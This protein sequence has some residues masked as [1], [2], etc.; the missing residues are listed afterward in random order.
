MRTDDTVPT[1]QW[2]VV[3]GA[4]CGLGREFARQL[5]ARGYHLV[6]VART[7]ER[8]GETSAEL[9][10][11]TC[12]VR[13]VTLDLARAGAAEELVAQTDAWG[14]VPEVL[15]N[16]AGIG[17]WGRFLECAPDRVRGLLQ[18]NASSLVLLSLLYGVRMRAKGRGYLLQVASTAAF[19]PV[20][21]FAVYA[22]TKSLVLSFSQALQYEGRKTGVSSTVLC[23]GPTATQFFTT[24]G[25]RPNRFF[26]AMMMPSAEVARH[27]LDAMFRRKAVHTPGFWNKLTVFLPRLLPAGWMVR[28]ADLFIK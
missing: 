4:S 13:T 1:G 26:Q 14:L 19:Q 28:A 24:A 6:L 11:D 27:G 22:A 16:N 25:L 15:V 23:P 5:A 9:A 12:L 10:S 3:T 2:A 7:A 8:L 17:A 21:S 18:L 20:P